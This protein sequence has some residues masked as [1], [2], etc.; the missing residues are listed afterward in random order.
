MGKSLFGTGFWI[1]VVAGLAYATW[2]HN[3]GFSQAGR[4]NANSG[5]ADSGSF[6]S[7]LGSRTI[8]IDKNTDLLTLQKYANEGNLA[9]QINLGNVHMT[10]RGVE[11][12]AQLAAKYY[13]MAALKSDPR[14]D[15]YL[16]HLYMRGGPGLAKS[17]RKSISH[18]KR[19]IEKGNIDATLDLAYAYGNPRFTGSKPDYEQAFL[20]SAIA[21]KHS[22]KSRIRQKAK[23]IYD[24]TAKSLP[25]RRKRQAQDRAD[26]WKP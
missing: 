13:H 17:R 8:V 19:A 4:A 1:I 7:R 2:E 21:M 6:L 22:R 10:G 16:G 14:G 15:Y 12:N 24:Y 5:D 18:F 20:W 9:A 25:P 23:R 11:K 3:D 26:H